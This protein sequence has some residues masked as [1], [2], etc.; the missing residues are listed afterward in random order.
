MKQ[1]NKNKN[2]GKFQSFENFT[3]KINYNDFSGITLYEKAL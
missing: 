3:K 2:I 1:Y